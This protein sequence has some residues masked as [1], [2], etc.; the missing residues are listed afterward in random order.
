MHGHGGSGGKAANG[1]RM[2]VKL[3]VLKGF[4]FEPLVNNKTVFTVVCD[5]IFEI[6]FNTSP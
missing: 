2:P 5:W 1:Y 3:I 6:N 4:F